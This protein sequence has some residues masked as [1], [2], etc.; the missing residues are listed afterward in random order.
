MAYN[1]Q[2]VLQLVKV[3]LNRLP[4]DTTLDVYLSARIK[5]ADAELTS[6]GILLE[7]GSTEDA[8]LLTDIVVWQ[9]GNRDNASG[10][11]DWLRLRR[12]ER[13]LQQTHRGDGA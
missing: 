8:L 10:M 6:V 9:Y 11:P 2:L 4:G 5:A 13:W 1:E 7:Q 12:K 3:R